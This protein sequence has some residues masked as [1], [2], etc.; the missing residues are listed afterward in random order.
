MKTVRTVF[1]GLLLIVFALLPILISGCLPPNPEPGPNPDPP[2]PNPPAPIVEGDWW[3]V[4]EESADR[5]PE[6]AAVLRVLQ[7]A[8]VNF[9]VYDDDSEDAAG[10]LD[11]VR[12]IRRPAL[13]VLDKDGTKLDARSLPQSADAMRAL[14]GG[15]Q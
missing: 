14:I 9:R 10:Y 12:G 7:T 5:T 4:I 1:F 11:A 8:G 13:L 2:D 15:E 6:T 3:I